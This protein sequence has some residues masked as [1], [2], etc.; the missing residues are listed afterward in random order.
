MTDRGRLIVLEGCDN[1]GKSTLADALSAQINAGG[2]STEVL[3]F[4]GQELGSLG[5]WVYDFHHALEANSVNG[6]SLQLLHIAAHID[7]IETRIKPLLEAGTDVILDRYW[8]STMVYGIVG[9]VSKQQLNQMIAVEK[10]SWG[11]DLPNC[12][13]LIH[14]IEAESTEEGAPLAEEYRK[15]ATAESEGHPVIEI[16]NEQSLQTT[17]NQML[18]SLHAVES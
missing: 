14:R 8:W 17:A 15:L 3:S 11:K 1:V 6:T 13:F 16:Q 18:K 2:R 4:P 10:E 12:V 9:G 5:R 7:S